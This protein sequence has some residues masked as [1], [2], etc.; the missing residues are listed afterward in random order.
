[1][2][3]RSPRTPFDPHYFYQ[4]AWIARRLAAQRPASHVDVGSSVLTMSVLSGF[5]DIRFI[6]VRPLEVH[7]PGLSSVPGDLGALP[8]ADRSTASLSCLHVIEHVGLGRYG[9]PMDPQ[10]HVRAAA[11]LTRVLQSGGRLYVAAPVGRERVCF[12]AHRVFAASTL[13][14]L[15]APLEVDEFSYVGDDGA[16]HEHQPLEAAAGLR[17]GCG[18]FVFRAP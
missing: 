6:D 3:D 15:F 12:N 11:E 17:Y 8:L 4:G 16:L 10:G 2:S 7:L 1:V 18:L 14:A 13:R 9:D 5:I